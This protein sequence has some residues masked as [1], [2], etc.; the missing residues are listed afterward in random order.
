MT[1]HQ[2]SEEG[3]EGLP[4]WTREDHDAQT[5]RLRPLADHL[6]IGH[7]VPDDE[8]RYRDTW[9]HI[10]LLAEEYFA[11]AEVGARAWDEGYEAAVSDTEARSAPPGPNGPVDPTRNPYAARTDALAAEAGGES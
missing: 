10:A 4:E 7:D 8:R 3:A 6:R 2:S 11:D 5:D 1:E 9:L